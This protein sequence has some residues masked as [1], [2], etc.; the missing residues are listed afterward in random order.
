M[1]YCQKDLFRRVVIYRSC[2]PQNSSGYGHAV[3]ISPLRSILNENTYDIFRFC[4]QNKM[5][6]YPDLEHGQLKMRIE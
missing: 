3:N 4:P 5:S 2:G 6:F 1:V